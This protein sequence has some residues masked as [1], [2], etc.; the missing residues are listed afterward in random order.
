MWIAA[1]AKS[2]AGVQGHP[3]DLRRPWMLHFFARY[4]EEILVM[5]PDALYYVFIQQ[6]LTMVSV[7]YKASLC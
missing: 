1:V 5:G 7:Y 2:R 6:K 4:V 3:A